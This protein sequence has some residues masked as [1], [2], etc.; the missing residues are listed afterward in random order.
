MDSLWSKIHFEILQETWTSNQ[1]AR[2]TH[3][4]VVIEEI[5][6]RLQGLL[7]MFRED[8]REEDEQEE[9]EEDPCGL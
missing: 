4:I 2:R 1:Q 5:I 3:M 8:E 6:K 7:E 9:M